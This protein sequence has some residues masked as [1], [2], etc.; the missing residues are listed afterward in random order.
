MMTVGFALDL[1]LAAVL[2]IS[3]LT[4]IKEPAEFAATLY[5]HHILPSW[6]IPGISRVCPWVEVA[7]AAALVVGLAPLLTA[8]L[9][10]ILIGTFCMIETIPLVNGSATNCGCYGT[11]HARKV[12]GSS[13]LTSAAL[14]GIAALHLWAVHD[15]EQVAWPWRLPAIALCGG[16]GLWLL[17]RV[18]RRRRVVTPLAST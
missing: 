15:G 10:V 12:D 5:R 16:A 11:G 3:G 2:G 14:I 9:V 6:S 18:M 13:V 4:K 8:A 7:L 17:W 1:Y